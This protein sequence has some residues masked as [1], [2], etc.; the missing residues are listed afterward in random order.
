MRTAVRSMSVAVCLATLSAGCGSGDNASVPGITATSVTI[1]SHQPLTGPAAAGFSEIAPAAKAYFD[2]VNARGGIHGR[3]IDFKYEDDAYNPANTV[4]VVHKLVEQE[5][6]FAVL[7]GLGTPT[8]TK[9]VDYL[10]SQHVPDLFVLSGCTCWDNPSKQPYTFGWSTDY[11]REGKILGTRIAQAFPGRKVAYFSQND[12]FGQD[13]VKGLDMTVPA[14]SV[15][16]RQ[17]YQPGTTDATPQM[18][19]IDQSGA[20]VIVAFANPANVAQLRIAQLKLGNKAQLVVNYSGSDPATLAHLLDSYA[21]ESGTGANSLIQGIITDSFITPATDTSSTWYKLFKAVRDQ[22]APSL[23]MDQYTNIGM[24]V[25]YSFTQ[26]LQKAGKNPTRESIVKTMQAN[27]LNGP[28]LV[29]F[30]FSNTSHAG[31]TGVQ[32]GVIQGD[33]ISL[34]GQPMTTDSSDG[35]VVP[36]TTAQAPAPED[37]VPSP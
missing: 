16:S 8:H 25:A 26:V 7:A 29:P 14:G 35:P 22:Y 31:Y 5:K 33:A 34:E 10:N 28:G 32:I 21:E 3:R 27:G 30:G 2:Y 18:T 15:V 9:V 6:V 11:I 17:T 13:G 24:S 20:D 19:A 23:P 36:Y 37:G 1:G 4:N 12:L